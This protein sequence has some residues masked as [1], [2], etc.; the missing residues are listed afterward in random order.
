[1]ANKWSESARD[2]FGEINYKLHPKTKALVRQLE[3]I[4]IRLNWLDNSKLTTEV[5]TDQKAH[6]S[7]ATTPRCRGGRY[8]IPKETKYVFII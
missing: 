7:I 8:S 3:R 1:M 6:F 2:N 4:Q 5:E